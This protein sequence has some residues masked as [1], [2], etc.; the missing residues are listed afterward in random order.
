MISASDLDKDSKIGI[1]NEKRVL[2]LRSG[3]KSVSV[4]AISKFSRIT[5][6]MVFNEV[7]ERCILPNFDVNIQKFKANVCNKFVV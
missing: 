5:F 4:N 1:T 2:S 3:D 6:N 7:K